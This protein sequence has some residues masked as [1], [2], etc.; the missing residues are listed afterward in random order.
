[1]VGIAAAH[2][3]NTVREL[4]TFGATRRS[5]VDYRHGTVDVMFKLRGFSFQSEL[6]FRSAPPSKTIQEVNDPASGQ[7]ISEVARNAWGWFA[8][9]GY[10]LSDH[11]EIAGRL[12]EVHPHG[13]SKGTQGRQAEYGG[14]LGYY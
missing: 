10:L 8:Q 14:A 7:R 12:G 9:A 13:A 2:N 1:M 4:S 11:V 6:L 5:P 3:S